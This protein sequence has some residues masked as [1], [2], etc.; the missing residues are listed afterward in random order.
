VT[1]LQTVVYCWYSPSACVGCVKTTTYQS[2]LS[3]WLCD[4]LIT[5]QA[6][7]H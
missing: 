5:P 4:K 1:S 6:S 2:L 7:T 3:N